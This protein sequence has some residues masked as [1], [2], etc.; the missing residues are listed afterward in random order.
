MPI[1]VRHVNTRPAFQVPSPSSL[2]EVARR[3]FGRRVGVGLP[4][5]TG[6]V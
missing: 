3:R 6:L 1:A 4:Y 2:G 5:G